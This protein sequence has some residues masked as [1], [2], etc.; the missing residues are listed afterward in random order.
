MLMLKFKWNSDLVQA[1]MLAAKLTFDVNK[2]L[3]SEPVSRIFNLAK[4]T[5][6]S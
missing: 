6:T 2:A 4:K 1:V 3:R 5:P